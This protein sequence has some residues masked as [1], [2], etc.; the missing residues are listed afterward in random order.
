[1]VPLMN[2]HPITQDEI[3]RM[4]R[5]GDPGFPDSL[6]KEVCRKYGRV[7]YLSFKLTN[8]DQLAP[9]DDAFLEKYLLPVFKKSLPHLV[10]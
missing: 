6:S 5:M 9:S 3:Q 10:Q 8:P 2:G 4:M 1:M 7:L